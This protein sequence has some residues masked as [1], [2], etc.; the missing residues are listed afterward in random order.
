[1]HPLVRESN[2]GPP[3]GR[4]HSCERASGARRHL[5]PVGS[6]PDAPL[7]QA[8]SRPGGGPW[9]TLPWSSPPTRAAKVPGSTWAC[10]NLTLKFAGQQGQPV[11]WEGLTAQAPPPDLCA[12]DAPL[13]PPS[14]CAPRATVRKET[15]PLHECSTGLQPSLAGGPARPRGPDCSKGPTHHSMSLRSLDISH[16]RSNI[17]MAAYKRD[18]PRPVVLLR[19]GPSPHCLGPN[20]PCGVGVGEKG[21]IGSPKPRLP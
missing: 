20:V 18:G 4:G 14:L 5:R 21:P 1:M 11:S 13:S 6:D 10:S 8:P 19:V 12:H 17:T 7:H 3:G 16:A 9:A 2:D 15:R